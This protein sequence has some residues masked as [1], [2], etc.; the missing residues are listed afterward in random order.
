MSNMA[1]KSFDRKVFA[2]GDKGGKRAEH[3]TPSTKGFSNRF[4]GECEG[5]K[6]CVFDCS[7]ARQAWIFKANLK[8]LSI[9]VGSTF[10]MG[11]L[12][13]TLVDTLCKVEVPEP[14]A[15]SNL[16]I[17]KLKL[18]RYV[19]DEAKLESETQKLYA[20]VYGQCTDYLVA[21]LEEHEDYAEMHP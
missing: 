19:N 21:R 8:K 3:Q 2:H 17:Y 12:V 16:E 4:T 1:G 10:E 14:E 18:A 15:V 20:L 9:Y 11:M 13:S 5:L 6:E 7:N